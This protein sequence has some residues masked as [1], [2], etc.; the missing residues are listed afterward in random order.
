[1]IKKKIQDLNIQE[2]KPIT[3]LFLP[4]P[5]HL[6]LLAT[7]KLPMLGTNV[8]HNLWVNSYPIVLYMQ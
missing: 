6:P 2:N 3:A 4:N 5:S 7:F 8:D 1:M